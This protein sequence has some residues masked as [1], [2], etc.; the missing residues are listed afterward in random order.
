[1]SKTLAKISPIA[2]AVCSMAMA[3]DE[4]RSHLNG[5]LIRPHHRGGCNIVGSNGH[6]LVACHDALAEASGP[7]IV[8]PPAKLIF[9]CRKVDNH[10]SAMLHIDRSE[11]DD[12][13]VGLLPDSD[14]I[15]YLDE[16]EVPKRKRVKGGFNWLTAWHKVLPSSLPKPGRDVPAI[17]GH[18]LRLIGDVSKTLCGTK[19]PAVRLHWNKTDRGA[20]CVTFQHG[21]SLNRLECVAVVMPMLADPM[22]WKIWR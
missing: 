21:L 10:L 5:I 1:M 8:C 2:A 9:K 20:V 15:E 16:I 3:K 4:I 7:L 13:L 12:K 14:T 11:V 22:P 18:Y 17:A 19:Y 6:V